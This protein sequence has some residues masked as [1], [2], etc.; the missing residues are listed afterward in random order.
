METQ[1]LSATVYRFILHCLA[2]W[3]SCVCSIGAAP[4][5]DHLYRLLMLDSQFGSPYEEIRAAV[6]ES[7]A[8]FGYEA[9]R[10]L[11]VTLY[12]A[13]NDE[14]RGI[15]LLTAEKAQAD[16]VYVG[17]TV[18]TLSAKQVYFGSDQP[19]VFAAPTDPVGIGVIDDFNSKPKANFTG[20]CYPVPGKARLRFI[21]HLL[22]Q[23][24]RFGLIYADMPQSRSYNAW[25]RQ[26]LTEDPDFKNMQ[27]IFRPVPLVTGERGDQQMAALAI[28]IIEEL[29]KQVD[30][31]ISANDQ[32][33][34]RR[35]FSELI[36]RYASKPLIGIVRNDVMEGWG[37][38]AVVFPSHESIGQ[39]A[40]RMI[41]DIFEGKPVAQIMPQWPAKYGYALDLQKTR[42]FGISV[43]VGILQLAG[44]N[45]VK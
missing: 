8:A 25:V 7:L 20:V 27:V 14:A 11:Q 5:T 30:A 6:L 12:T 44:G 1:R 13:G 31:F 37:A 24:R 15:A 40:A 17:G 19:V 41:R 36:D 33:G 22:P 28:P 26:L 3:L 18:A 4:Q 9:G 45:I 16:V 21:H 23:A 29:D 35:A 39:Q 32:L 42:R 2:V 38:M 34:S 43:P 10:N